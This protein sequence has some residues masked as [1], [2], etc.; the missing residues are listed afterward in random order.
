MAINFDLEQL[1]QQHDCKIWFETGLWNADHNVSSKKALACGFEKVFCV[2]IMEKWVDKG[3]KVFAPEIASGRYTLIHDDSTNMGTY[4]GEYV[5]N[6]KTMFFLDA[7]VDAPDIHGYKKRCP[8]LEEIDIIGQLPR[9]D[10][11]ILVN[12]MRLFGCFWGE[13]SYGKIDVLE[14]IKYQI[15]SINP[16]YKFGTLN[17]HVENDVLIAYV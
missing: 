1:R 11:V 10:N 16:N 13:K 6:D 14:V 17:G 4:L 5:L 8:L 3:K 7:H 2:E 9:K 12:D 15:K